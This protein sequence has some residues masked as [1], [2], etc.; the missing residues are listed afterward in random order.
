MTRRS[1]GLGGWRSSFALMISGVMIHRM[2]FETTRG[3]KWEDLMAL[4][5]SG[6]AVDLAKETRWIDARGM[7][8][9]YRK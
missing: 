3:F 7:I 4:R 5:K 9:D 1:H 6:M 2:T 8:E